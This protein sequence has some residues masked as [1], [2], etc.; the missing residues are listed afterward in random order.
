MRFGIFYEFQLPRPWAPDDEHRLIKEALEQVE[1]ADFARNLIAKFLQQQPER[2]DPDEP[3]HK[4]KDRD[5]DKEQDPTKI[6][7]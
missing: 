3:K 7:P 6:A 2:K 5:K 4:P 1:L